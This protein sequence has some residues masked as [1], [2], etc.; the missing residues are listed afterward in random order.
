[1][2]RVRSLYHWLRNV[3]ANEGYT[4]RKL[5]DAVD[6]LGTGNIE[7]VKRS[8]AAEGFVLLPRRSMVE[9]TSAWLNRSRRLAKNLDTAIE[10]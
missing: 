5:K 7:I 3:F 2:A 1:M 9:R 10:C 6:G 8:D 4:D